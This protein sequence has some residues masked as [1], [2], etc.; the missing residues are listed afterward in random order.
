MISTCNGQD[1]TSS[2]GAVWLVFKASLIRWTDGS[3]YGTDGMVVACLPLFPEHSI[4]AFLYRER[5]DCSL[6]KLCEGVSRLLWHDQAKS[7]VQYILVDCL[8]LNR[9]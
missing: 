5:Q 3:A 2:D 1:N 7:G 9:D 6:F 8:A 4:C